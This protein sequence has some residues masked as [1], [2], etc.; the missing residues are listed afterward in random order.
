MH[1]LTTHFTLEELTVTQVRGAN[2]TPPTGLIPALQDTADRMENVRDLL[3]HPIIVTSGYRSPEVNKAV[4]ASPTSAHIGG[5]AIDFICPAAG[6]PREVAA[7]I[8]ASLIDF[9]QLIAEGSWVHISFDPQLR[10]QVLTAHFNDGKTTYT[11][12]LA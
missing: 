7:Q 6:T 12:G 10:K 1:K 9:D 5:R 11:K 3:G 8:A 4:G 2:N